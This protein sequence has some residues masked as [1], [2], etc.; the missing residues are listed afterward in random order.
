MTESHLREDEGAQS[1]HLKHVDVHVE[2]SQQHGADVDVADVED[3]E[4]FRQDVNSEQ[5]LRQQRVNGVFY[6][7]LLPFFT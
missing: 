6:K 1:L 5:R 3:L 2:M 7:R 4:H